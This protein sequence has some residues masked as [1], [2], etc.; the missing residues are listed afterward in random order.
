[1][2][3]RGPLHGV[4]VLDLACGRAGSVATMLLADLGADVVRAEARDGTHRRVA[5]TEDAGPVCW[6]RGK[7]RVIVGRLDAR[8]DPA[9]A[10]L[11]ARADA[12]VVDATPVDRAARR[13]EPE[14][15][16]AANP[17]LV[18]AHVA[19][20]GAH[21]EGAALPEDPLLLAALSGFA[22][23][24]TS[25]E[26]APVAPVVPFVSNIHGVLAAA[27]VVAALAERRRSGHGQIVTTTGPNTAALLLATLNPRSLDRPMA[28]TSGRD[29]RGSA[30]F[31]LY[32][33]GDGL[34]FFL[35]ALTPAIFLTALDAIDLLEVMVLPGMDG[36][37]MNLYV[38]DN[39]LRVAQALEARFAGA[40]RAHW[41][42]VL[43]AAGVPAAAVQTRE[44]WRTSEPYA[45][46][47]GDVVHAHPEAGAVT[48][49]A[50]PL[51]FPA[52]PTRPG[53]FARSADAAD[54]VWREPR[55]DAGPDVAGPPPVDAPLAG[56]RVIDLST[57][58][59]G[60]MAPTLLGQWGADVVKVET[61]DGDPYR[62]YNV[63]Y[64]AANQGKRRV[65]LDLATGA[66][67]DALLALVRDADVVVDN[68]RPSVRRKLG[69]TTERLHTVTARVVHATINAFGDDGPWAEA[70]GFDPVIQACSGLMHACG[71]DA[72][73]YY[74]S[75][76]VHDVATGTLLTLGVLA[77]LHDRATTGRGGRVQLSLA[78]SSALVQ[79]EELVSYAARPATARGGPGTRGPGPTHRFVRARDGW[80][81]VAAPT[82]ARDEALLAV[83]AGAE[84]RAVAEVL[85]DLGRLGAPAVRVVERDEY[86]TAAHLVAHRHVHV[87][88][89]DEMGR[90]L[91][92]DQIAAWSRSTPIDTT[93]APARTPAAPQWR[94]P[95][96]GT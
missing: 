90:C 69:I 91:V 40:P 60:P 74:T 27:S 59:A 15:L 67:L 55:A 44:E 81:A 46:A 96:D 54:D 87:V 13:C 83:L 85:D 42:A 49:A 73:P 20:N 16:L 66:G 82:R 3:E 62:V 17:S 36:E 70:P 63:S 80:L 23:W 10:E 32:R 92:V 12:V 47:V 77:A 1:M 93:E 31:R 88:H 52:T 29:V 19:P 68:F 33:C 35:G 57:F 78:S 89:D 22:Q 58:L 25:T 45:A 79:C 75:T 7:A 21:G 2:G 9:L 61:P 56:L 64:V 39:G 65:V 26:D 50:S 71:D 30:S 24:Q 72:H 51:R 6:D 53:P 84:A 11:V 4:R 28:Y 48:L 14:Q 34:S 43:G 8:D 95:D 37:F 5:P 76:P 38:G 41:L 18:V 94:G 86:E